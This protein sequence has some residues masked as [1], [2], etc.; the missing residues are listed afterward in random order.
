MEDLIFKYN[1]KV[2]KLRS[3]I[4]ELNKIG[5]KLANEITL[6]DDVDS[7][8]S[9]KI[10]LLDD[11]TNKELLIQDVYAKALDELD[12]IELKQYN[13][14]KFYSDCESIIKMFI[15]R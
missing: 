7:E 5:F 8:V 6:I 1:T 12:K 13:Y 2:T 15:V 9:K 4:S 11:D 10:N 14:Y 3:N